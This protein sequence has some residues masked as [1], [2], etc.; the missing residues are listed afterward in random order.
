VEVWSFFNRY[1][2]LFAAM[3]FSLKSSSNKHVMKKWGVFLVGKP[4]YHLTVTDNWATKC[5]ILC[6]SNT[7]GK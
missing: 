2:F 6:R 1:F 7:S 3:N 5:S 4:I